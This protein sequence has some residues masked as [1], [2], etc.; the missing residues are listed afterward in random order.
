MMSSL[1]KRCRSADTSSR[2]ANGRRRKPCDTG[3]TKLIY[4]RC[5]AVS[6]NNSEVC[7]KGWISSHMGVGDDVDLLTCGVTEVKAQQVK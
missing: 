3:R 6:C 2:S 4:L 1:S 7:K 5:M